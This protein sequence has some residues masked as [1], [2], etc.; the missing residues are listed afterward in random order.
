MIRPMIF[1][2]LKLEHNNNHNVKPVKQAGSSLFNGWGEDRPKLSIT[3]FGNNMYSYAN[4]LKWMINQ[5]NIN[6][7]LSKLRLFPKRFS[8]LGNGAEIM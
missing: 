4:V 8:L 5:S 3:F 2:W 7:I 6:K 1:N